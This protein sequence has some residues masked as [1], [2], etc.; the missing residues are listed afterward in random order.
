[1]SGFGSVTQNK[2]QV[3]LIALTKITWYHTLF[4]EDNRIHHYIAWVTMWSLPLPLHV[5]SEVDSIKCKLI[6]IFSKSLI[7][8]PNT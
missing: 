8:I 7:D 4:I 2:Y 3:A 1:M 6:I 5:E